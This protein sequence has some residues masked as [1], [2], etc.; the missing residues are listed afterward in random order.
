MSVAE[1]ANKCKVIAV[2]EF[3]GGVGK[4]T[5]SICLGA[6][7]ASVGK[8]IL[9]IDLDP[10]GCLTVGLGFSKAVKITVKTKLEDMILEDTIERA[11][12]EVP[13]ESDYKEGII[14]HAEGMD[15]LPT[16]KLLSNLDIL[17][18]IPEKELLLKKYIEKIRK[19]YNFIIIDCPPHFGD[20]TTNAICAAD[21]VLIP[22]Q[23]RYLDIDGMNEFF[24][25]INGF[26]SHHNPSLSIEGI[27]YTMDNANYNNSK[28]CKAAV[29]DKFASKYRIYDFS[30]PRVE[31]LAE[32]TAFGMSIFSYD[33]NCKGASCYEKLA[34]E[35]MAN[36]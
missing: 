15:V 25:T 4:T 9:L 18:N 28:M 22:V 11:G 29:N 19:D 1:S 27:I 17:T 35:V 26:K 33:K 8:K 34:L 21:S 30:I 7:M 32:A 6:Y 36:A 23:P 24:S 14:K 20:L 13:Y 2:S 31:K 5:T 10:Q 3:K 16:N 12:D